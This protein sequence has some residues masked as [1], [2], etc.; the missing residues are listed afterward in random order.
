MQLWCCERKTSVW[1]PNRRIGH[2][3]KLLQAVA[4]MVVDVAAAHVAIEYRCQVE[5]R[6]AQTELHRRRMRRT[7]A[8]CV[9]VS[10]FDWRRRQK[11][12]RPQLIVQLQV[13]VV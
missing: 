13:R 1:A 8:R 10:R 4:V 5:R 11:V 7:K 3:P 6:A 9:P 2:A 12:T